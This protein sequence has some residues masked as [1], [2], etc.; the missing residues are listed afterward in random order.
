MGTP[1][2][3]HLKLEKNWGQSQ[4]SQG[5]LWIRLTGMSNGVSLW[6]RL[7]YHLYHVL[8]HDER[9]TLLFDFNWLQSK[10]NETDIKE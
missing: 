10:V 9:R 8:R 6:Y 2:R 3:L 7:K 1:A 4:R 5:G